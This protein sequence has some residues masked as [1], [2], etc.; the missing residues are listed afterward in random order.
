MGAEAHDEPN[1][2]PS[3][4]CKFVGPRDCPCRC[5]AS[6]QYGVLNDRCGAPATTKRER[7]NGGEEWDV[8][9]KHARFLDRLR[10]SIRQNAELLAKLKEA[11]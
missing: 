1:C 9:D 4:D 10:K 7:P 3:V 5:H 2:D 6:C 11:E 8:C